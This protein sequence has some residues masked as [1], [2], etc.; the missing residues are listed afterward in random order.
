ME[1]MDREEVEG[2]GRQRAEAREAYEASLSPDT[3]AHF[4]DIAVDSTIDAGNAVLRE[5]SEAGQ[6]IAEVGVGHFVAEN[7]LDKGERGTKAAGAS[8]AGV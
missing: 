7:T 2:R 5:Q 3:T 4:E 8:V 1:D 6:S